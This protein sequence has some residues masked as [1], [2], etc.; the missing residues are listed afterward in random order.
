MRYS[1]IFCYHVYNY[2]FWFRIFGY[3]LVIKNWKK[4]GL[5]FSERNFE[6]IGLPIYIIGYYIIKGLKPD[7]Y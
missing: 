7:K 2:S 3:G 6:Q 4:V 1:K 5:T